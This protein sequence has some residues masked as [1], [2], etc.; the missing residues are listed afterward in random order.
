MIFGRFK[1][2]THSIEF[3]KRG[4]PHVNLIV[5]LDRDTHFTPSELDEIIYAEIP[6]THLKDGT[7]NPM[8][9]IVHVAWSLSTGLEVLQRRT[10]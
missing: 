8:Y 3:Q 9:N 5:W 4:F 1:A 6:D 7:E 10:L 2:R